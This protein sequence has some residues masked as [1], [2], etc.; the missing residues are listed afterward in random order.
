PDRSDLRVG[1]LGPL[2]LRL[3]R[4]PECPLADDVALDLG[5]AAPDR[6]GAAEKEARLQVAHGVVVA[7]APVPGQEPLGTAGALEHLCAHPKYV[8]S[9]LHRPTVRF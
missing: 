9:E 1:C 4:Q 6:L 8:Q 3:L 2:D 7:P 5:G